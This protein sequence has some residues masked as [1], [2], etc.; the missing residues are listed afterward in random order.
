MFFVWRVTC[1]LMG[2]VSCEADDLSTCTYG[3]MGQLLHLCM[4]GRSLFGLVATFSGTLALISLS[5]IL[6]GVCMP[7]R[8][9]GGTLPSGGG[10]Y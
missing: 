8:V 3:Q 10:H 9:E 5:F 1:V 7:L 6:G 4:P 2:M